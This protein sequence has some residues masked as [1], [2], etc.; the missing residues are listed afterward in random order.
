MT[1]KPHVVKHLQCWW[2]QRKGW[3]PLWREDKVAQMLGIE[4]YGCSRCGH[5]AIAERDDG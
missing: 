5:G 3:M 2:L 4:Q 1:E